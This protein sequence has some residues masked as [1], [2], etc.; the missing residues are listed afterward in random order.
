MPFKEYHH[1]RDEVPDTRSDPVASF[2][3]LPIS[4]ACYWLLGTGTKY[5]NRRGFGGLV[6]SFALPVIVL[7]SVYGSAASGLEPVALVWRW[8][9]ACSQASLATEQDPP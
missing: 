4:S 2:G 7:R 5:R 8:Y 6:N 3:F 1:L 9:D